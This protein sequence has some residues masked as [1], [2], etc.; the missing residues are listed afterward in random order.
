MKFKLIFFTS[1]FA[2][3]LLYTEAQDHTDAVIIGHVVSRG[4]HI[5]FFWKQ[6]K[7]ILHF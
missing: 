5:P 7:I 3:G 4:E 2:L 6:R 1:L